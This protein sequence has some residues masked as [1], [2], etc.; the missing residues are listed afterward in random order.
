[1]H[2]CGIGTFILMMILLGAMLINEYRKGNIIWD[3][4]AWMI[5]QKNPADRTA[6]RLKKHSTDN[7]NISLG[8]IK[9]V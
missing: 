6:G 1:V 3:T 5:R 7:Y 4:S 8:E 2:D 9:D